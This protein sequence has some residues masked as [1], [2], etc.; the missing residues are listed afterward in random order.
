MGCVDSKPKVNR[1]N[2]GKSEDITN[3]NIVHVNPEGPT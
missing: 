1:N 3:Q 2:I